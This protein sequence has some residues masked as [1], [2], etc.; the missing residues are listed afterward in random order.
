MTSISADTRLSRA[1][2]VHQSLLEVKTIAGVEDRL[3]ILNATFA[4]AIVMGL[5]LWPWLAAAFALHLVAARLTRRDPYLRRIY[6][7]YARQ[8]DHYEP[9]PRTGMTCNRRPRG[10]G[11]DLLC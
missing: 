9:W 8:A 5:G 7:R 1:S 10:F 3:A 6:I 4:L 11:R 2:L